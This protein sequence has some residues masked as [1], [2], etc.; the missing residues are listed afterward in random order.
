MDTAFV[1]GATGFIGRHI[2]EAIRGRGREVRCLVR[3]PS[4][5]D[6]L[7]RQGIELVTG[8]LEDVGGWA[9][10]LAGCDT[11]FHAGGLVAARRRS[12]LFAINGRAVGRLAAACAALP[13]PPTFVHVSSLAAAGPTTTAAARAEHEPPAP[14]S[15]YG[16]SK[17]EGEAELERL[18]A[19]LPITVLR[20][21]I[22]FGPHDRNVTQI[23]QMIHAS[24]LHLLMGFHDPRLSLIHAADLA[25]LALAAADRGE[26]LAADAAA[27]PCGRGFY[28]ACDDSEHPT[29]SELG[30]R[31]A[32]GLGRSVIVLPLPLLL[33]LPTSCAV[34]AFW[35][36]LGQASIVSPDKLREAIA[37]SW[38]ASGRKAREQLGFTPAAKLDERLRETADWMQTSRRL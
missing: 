13:N 4:R 19:G 37:P 14:V 2:V 18:A 3:S 26:R 32:A 5:A 8:S 11:V 28:H 36:L 24:R 35:N 6:H 21:G 31:I 38:A 29:Y 23:F 16:R 17:R 9:Q 30:R 15:R 33:A 20:P 27:D 34:E 25:T 22:V 12:E 7:R 1:T 10:R